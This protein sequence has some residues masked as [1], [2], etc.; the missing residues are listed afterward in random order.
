[1]I[2]SRNKIFTIG[3]LVSHILYGPDWVG[4]VLRFGTGADSLTKRR[5]VLIHMVPG[6]TY[7]KHFA[8]SYI[9]RRESQLS[10]WVAE[11][12]LRKIEKDFS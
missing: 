9:A 4:L 5:S 12:W 8:K 10:G 2:L 1:M 6:T 3:D 11:N 7:D